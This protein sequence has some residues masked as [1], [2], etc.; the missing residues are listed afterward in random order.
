MIVITG[1]TVGRITVYPMDAEPGFVSQHVAICR[2]PSEVVPRFAFWG[3]HN[4]KGR[5]QLL[6]QRYGQGKPGL[7]LTN[8]RNLTLPLPPI[9]EQQRVVVSL[10]RFERSSRHVIEMQR[11]RRSELEALLPSI[12][13]KAFR[14]EL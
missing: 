3:L 4:S 11:Q 6:G 2:V 5:E 10:E 14:G 12:L 1:S 8:I 7:N 13:D 9:E